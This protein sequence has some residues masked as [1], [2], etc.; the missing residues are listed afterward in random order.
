M[1]STQRWCVNRPVHSP[2]LASR[3]NV[4]MS[5]IVSSGKGDGIISSAVLT[6]F[7][8]RSSP[9]SASSDDRRGGTAKGGGA[10]L[11]GGGGVPVETASLD[12]PAVATRRAIRAIRADARTLE[13]RSES[14][15]GSSILGSPVCYILG[16]SILGYNHFRQ[17]HFRHE[18]CRYRTVGRVNT[19]TRASRRMRTGG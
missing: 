12:W 4:R 5:W 18:V 13:R 3:P 16:S 9:S 19:Q 6:A 8:M 10:G 17:Q 14:R 11:G 1:P 15:R 7:L 2:A